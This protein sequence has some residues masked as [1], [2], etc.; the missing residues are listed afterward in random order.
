MKYI[1]KLF[2]LFIC[3]LSGSVNAREILVTDYGINPGT[4]ENA[5]PAVKNALEAC[6]KETHAILVFPKG[7]YDFY[8]DKGLKQ[9]IGLIINRQHN[10][11]IEGNGSEFIFHGNM[12]IISVSGSTDITMRNF[13]VDWERPFISQG[14]I[15]ATTNNYIDIN[16]DKKQYP[17]TIENERIIFTGEDWKRSVEWHNLYDK[18]KQEIVY[19]TLDMPLGNELFSNFKTEETADGQI[20]IYTPMLWKPEPGTYITMWH[21]RYIRN[22][23]GISQSKNILLENIT[24]YH[25]L[26]N[27]V[28]GTRSENI[29]MRNVNMAANEAKGRVFSL[30]ADASHFNTC[31]G[32]IKV[33]NCA[34]TGQGDDFINIHGMN[35]KVE[36]KIDDYSI[37]VPPAG[38]ASSRGT[39]SEGDE[40]WFINGQTSQR[41]ESRVIASITD[42]MEGGKRTGYIVSFKRKLPA[43]IQAGDFMENKSWVPNVHILNCRIL[44]KHRARGILVSTPGKVVIENNYFRTAGA[45]IL[46]EGDTNY[47]YESG[48]CTDVTIRNNTFE[49]CLTSKW[50]DGIIAITPSHRPQNTTETP[51]HTNIKIENNTFKHFDCTLVYARSTNNLTF[52]KNKIERTYNYKPYNGMYG[53]ILDGCHNVSI[54]GNTYTT[55][56]DG[57]NICITH[58]KDT[59]IK[60]R[61]KE[62]KLIIK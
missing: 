48:A 55:D 27:G 5:L 1:T 39:F 56:F 19:R 3:V 42:R 36:E 35:M 12:S 17:Y 51:Y 25:A 45:A 23:I 6:R 43:D 16:I 50:G 32:L 11:I 26:S 40:M 10:L 41:G 28:L 59:E 34:H 4:K 9:D 52:N 13:T 46:I 2:V 54:K 62:L 61:D 33:E 20:R 14:R 18:D 44:K 37:L 60:N 53:F 57:K 15:T 21:G 30:I 24:V 47:W 38:K 29:T 7:R 31:R 58:M 22:G 8:P 49:D